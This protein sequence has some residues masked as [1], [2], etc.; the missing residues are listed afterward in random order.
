MSSSELLST[1]P[2]FA[3]RAEL[4]SSYLSEGCR[5]QVLPINKC[6]LDNFK[7]AVTVNSKLFFCWVYF[8]SAKFSLI[9]RQVG[10]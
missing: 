8:S 5:F 3:A 10:I 2:F 7:E 9:Q 4:A 6:L 1:F